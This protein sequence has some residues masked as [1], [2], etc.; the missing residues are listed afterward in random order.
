MTC[1]QVRG[2][3]GAQGSVP[4]EPL[5]EVARL[6]HVDAWAVACR[7]DPEEVQARSRADVREAETALRIN[8]DRPDEVPVQLARTLW[9]IWPWVAGRQP[10]R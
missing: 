5:A 8:I 2:L 7:L 3:P 6:S 9:T 4:L 1:W 10:A